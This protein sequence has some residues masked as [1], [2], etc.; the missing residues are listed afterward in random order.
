MPVALRS[1]LF[2]LTCAAYAV[3]TFVFALR[4]RGE[5]GHAPAP[6][7]APWVL[8]LGCLTHGVLLVDALWVSHN[9]SARALSAIGLLLAALFLGVRQ[10]N[11]RTD[12]LASVVLPAAT[13][14]VVIG[15]AMPVPLREGGPPVAH[16]LQLALHVAANIVGEALLLFAGASAGAYLVADKRLKQ[17]ARQPITAALP[18][19]GALDRAGHHLTVAG[20]VLL[21]VGLALAPAG[22]LTFAG[23]S[24]ARLRTLFGLLSWALLATVLAARTFAGWRGRRSALGTLSGVAVATFV[25]A[26]YAVRSLALGGSP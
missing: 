11:A 25:V 24:S 7:Y 17:K 23:S 1:L 26:A 19:L 8:L 5:R 6:R 21:T 18:S 20:F 22:G 13:L 9:L 2:A 14:L 16:S 4:D 3:G 15:E 12:W 10:W